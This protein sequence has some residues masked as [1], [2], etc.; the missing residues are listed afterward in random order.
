MAQSV[1]GICVEHKMCTTSSEKMKYEDLICVHISHQET[2]ADRL[3]RG[4]LYWVGRSL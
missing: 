4:D 1:S 2:G 3:F